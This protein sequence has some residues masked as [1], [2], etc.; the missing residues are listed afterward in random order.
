MDRVSRQSD[1][2]QQCAG[3]GSGAAKPGSA[4]RVLSESD[5]MVKV[6]IAG[7]ALNISVLLS[8]GFERHSAE[9]LSPLSGA[10]P[11]SLLS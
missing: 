5:W 10:P 3:V 2:G 11:F 6:S 7:M 8:M 1:R 9:T 4:S